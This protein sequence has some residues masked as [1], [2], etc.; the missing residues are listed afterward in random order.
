[1]P[2]MTNPTTPSKSPE[3]T[4]NAVDSPTKGNED[5]QNDL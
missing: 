1:M 3:P 4:A 2:T 5:L